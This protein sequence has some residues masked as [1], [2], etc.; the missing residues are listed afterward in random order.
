MHKTQTT[1][2]SFVPS[3]VANLSYC[4]AKTQGQSLNSL[5]FNSNSAVKPATK[6]LYTSGN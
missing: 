2:W 3:T 1:D 5:Q 4:V 6:T